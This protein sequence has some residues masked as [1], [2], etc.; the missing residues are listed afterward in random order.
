MILSFT[1]TRRAP[2]PEVQQRALVAH[3]IRDLPIL[4]LHGGAPGS[5]EMFHDLLRELAPGAIIE[6]YPASGDRYRYWYRRRVTSGLHHPLPPLTRN[7]I[8][9]RRCDRL[10][11]C[12]AQVE[13]IIRSGTWYTV[14]QARL[15]SKPITLIL[16]DGSVKEERC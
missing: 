4:V 2:L 8:I 12:P 5:D 6:V 13:E 11:A 1:G 3:L 7:R 10:L 14:R 9:A 16:P 15:F